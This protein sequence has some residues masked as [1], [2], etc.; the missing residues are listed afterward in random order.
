MD[1]RWKVAI[2]AVLIAAMFMT[3]AGLDT[4]FGAAN[5]K[6]TASPTQ[7]QQQMQQQQ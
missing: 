4:A 2:S 6:L 5:A 1:D 7:R 3:A